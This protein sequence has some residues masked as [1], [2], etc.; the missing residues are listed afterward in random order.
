MIGRERRGED[1]QPKA[2]GNVLEVEEDLKA[3]DVRTPFGHL[4]FK[5]RHLWLAVAVTVFIALLNVQ[6]VEG[7]EANRCFAILVFATILWAT[8]VGVYRYINRCGRV[9]LTCF[10]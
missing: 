8:E 1:G 6:T 2:I 5:R 9:V 10:P 7:F 3:L 4:R